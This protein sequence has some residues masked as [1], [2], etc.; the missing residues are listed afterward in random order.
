MWI[1]IYRNAAPKFIF[2]KIAY[3]MIGYFA[4]G[5]I[6]EILLLT[7]MRPYYNNKSPLE[8]ELDLPESHPGKERHEQQTTS[9]YCFIDL[10]VLGGSHIVLVAWKKLAQP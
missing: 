4:P 3:R 9:H 6:G 1:T 7:E 5:Q 10:R 2:S 8:R